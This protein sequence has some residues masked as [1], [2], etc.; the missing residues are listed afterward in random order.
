MLKNSA[1][2]LMVKINVEIV[3][4]FREIKSLIIEKEMS[5]NSYSFGFKV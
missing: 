5:R 4:Q 2:V 1:F 3:E